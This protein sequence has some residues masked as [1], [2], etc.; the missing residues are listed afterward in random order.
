MKTKLFLTGLAIIAISV[1]ANAQE[2]G[3]GQGQGKGNCQGI[4][5]GSTFVDSNKDGVCDNQ[6]KRTTNTT[7]NKGNG[8]C[9]GNGQGQGCGQGLGKGKK[10]LDAN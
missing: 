4:C 6:G 2:S 3:A 8:T 5:K 9:K 7:G 1:F 10:I